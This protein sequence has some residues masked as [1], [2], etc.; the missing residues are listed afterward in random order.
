MQ[1]EYEA[2]KA[3]RIAI[4]AAIKQEESANSNFDIVSKKYEHGM[5]PQIVYLDAQ[6]VYVQA[7][8][9]KTIAY[10]QFLIQHARLERATAMFNLE[11]SNQL[12]Q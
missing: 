6:N 4:D 9:N 12:N 11:Q 2:L 3:A 7:A 1:E 5:T 8:I 10:A